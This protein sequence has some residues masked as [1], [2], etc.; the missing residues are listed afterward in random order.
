MQGPHS[1]GPARHLTQANDHRIPEQA[2][3][4]FEV[5]EELG[6][7]ALAHDRSGR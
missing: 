2:G 7:V 3:R 5:V 6:P 4:S 1:H